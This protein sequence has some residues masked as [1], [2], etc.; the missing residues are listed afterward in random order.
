MTRA[1]ALLVALA[2]GLAGAVA[3]RDALHNDGRSLLAGAV[4]GTN[5]FPYHQCTSKDPAGTPCYF[6]MP[7]VTRL[8]ASVANVTDASE[9][10]FTVKC[11]GCNGNNTCCAA[12]TANIK[13]IV[14]NMQ[15]GCKS[16]IKYFWQPLSVNGE[17]RESGVYVDNIGPNGTATI[18]TMVR[19]TAVNVP[20]KELNGWRICIRAR[21]PCNTLETAF[22]TTKEGGFPQVAM[23]DS[24]D[25]DN[26]CCP[27][28]YPELPPPP[29]P[30]PRPPPPSPRPPRPPPPSPRPPPACAVCSEVRIV[31]P[32]ELGDR[33][34]FTFDEARC[35]DFGSYV[36]D[37][38]N[39]KAQDL[40]ARLLK[41]FSVTSCNGT[42]DLDEQTYP[43]LTVCGQFFSAEE[44]Q[45]LQDDIL[46]MME[47]WLSYLQ[48]RQDCPVVLAGYSLT[49]ETKEAGSDSVETGCLHGRVSKQCAPLTP[50]PPPPPP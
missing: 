16:A 33:T 35:E 6:G 26:G 27:S 20:S 37:S 40:Q 41:P 47:D 45:K 1:T 43:T 18:A 21:A 14:F 34:L 36:E 24:S 17:P 50:P 13:K 30:R 4:S 23:M 11:P 7:T 10:C 44:G 29:S 42:Y 3:E 28:R 32:R 31:P 12:L 2:V 19:L 38:L 15:P 39:S 46:D 48:D 9:F 5:T 22:I 25:G 8:N 49:A